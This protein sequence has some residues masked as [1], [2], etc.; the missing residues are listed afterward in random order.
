MKKRNRQVF[1]EG[2]ESRKPFKGNNSLPTK[3]RIERELITKA[4]KQLNHV[5]IA[6]DSREMKISAFIHG[7]RHKA[8]MCR[9]LIF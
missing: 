7:Q 6:T 5:E 9:N 2:K 3:E 4:C 1:I 8:Q